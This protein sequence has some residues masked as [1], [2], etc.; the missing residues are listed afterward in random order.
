[1]RALQCIADGAVEGILGH[2]ELGRGW[3]GYGDGRFLD[4]GQGWV[5]SRLMVSTD[6]VE[7]RRKKNADGRWRVREEGEGRRG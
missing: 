7:M 5:L 2:D 1:M 6:L 4:C 3:A